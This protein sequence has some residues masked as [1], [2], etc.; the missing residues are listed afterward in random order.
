MFH[1]SKIDA[2]H[3]RA[4]KPFSHPLKS[5]KGGAKRVPKSPKFRKAGLKF[6]EKISLW[7]S[8]TSNFYNLVSIKGQF[9]GFWL[10]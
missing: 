5:L 9:F 3:V 2:W 4:I 8:K 6:R 7:V 10:L 1:L